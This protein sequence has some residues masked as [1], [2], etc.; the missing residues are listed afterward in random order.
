MRITNGMMQ[1]SALNSLYKNMT[2]LDKLLDQMSTLKKIQKP[3][4]DP[5]VAGRT[6]KLT[7]DVTAI[8]Q[9]QS[10][11]EEAM[12]WMEVTDS[13][14]TNMNSIMQEI[15]TR[16]V[17]AANGPLEEADREKILTDI[18]QLT[19]QLKQE[20]NVTYAGRYVFSGKWM[21]S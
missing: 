11:V 5:I 20:A 3:S 2:S 17:Q 19:E 18:Q 1:A 21:K 14:F 9:Y 6:L 16:L 4:D 7:I 15:N 8:T 12:S 10:N 13:A